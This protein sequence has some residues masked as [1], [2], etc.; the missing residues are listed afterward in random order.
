MKKSRLCTKFSFVYAIVYIAETTPLSC[1]FEQ[2]VHAR[3]VSRPL[4]DPERKLHR[5]VCI[6]FF[7][8]A[9]PPLPV[10]PCCAVLLHPVDDAVMIADD[11]IRYE[12]VTFDERGRSP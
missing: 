11:R 2:N 9:P 4:I 6:L 12:H 3:I 8:F 1:S 5:Y 7:F 10:G